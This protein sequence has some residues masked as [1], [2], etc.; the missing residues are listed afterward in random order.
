MRHRPRPGK[1]G[2]FKEL[3]TPNTPSNSSTYVLSNGLT[4]ACCSPHGA[5]SSRHHMAPSDVFLFFS[6]SPNK[7]NQGTTGAAFFISVKAP[8]KKIKEQPGQRW[9]LLINTHVTPRHDSHRDL[10]NL[11][12]MSRVGMASRY[13]VEYSR[14]RRR[15]IDPP[16][17]LSPSLPS[18]LP[19]NY[20]TGHPK[21]YRQ[22]RCQPSLPRLHDRKKMETRLCYRVLQRYG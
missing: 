12:T 18:I 7:I 21:R 2:A 16:P 17:S 14:S 4:S 3:L 9:C 22:R 11:Q 13:R 6:Q 19:A 10:G 20:F 5:G 8:T 1:Q 15:R